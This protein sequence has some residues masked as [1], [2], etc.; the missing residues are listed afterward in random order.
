MWALIVQFWNAN[1]ANILVSLLVGFVFFVLGP[2]GLWFSGKKIRKERVRKAKET[3]IDL[4][5]GMVVN[6]ANVDEDKL[7]SVFRAVEREIDTDLSGDYHIDHW[8][9]DVV[10]RFEKSRHLSAEQKQSYYDAVRKITDEIQSKTD[11]KPVVEVPRKY[12]PIL[13]ELKIALSD[14]EADKASAAVSELERALI[15]R[16]R[17]QDPV[18]NVFRFYRWM[19]KRSPFTFITTFGVAVGIYAFVLYKF[20]PRLPF[21]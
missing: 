9:G 11:K 7:R 10:L 16:E 5:E 17:T 2:L 1:S 15:H 14:N 19:Y 6:Q 4:L 20:L 21:Y 13:N 18:L 3:L 12:E 8:L